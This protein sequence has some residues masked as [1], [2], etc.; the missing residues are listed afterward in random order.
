MDAPFRIVYGIFGQGVV[1]LC[2][3][4][5]HEG[6]KMEKRLCAMGFFCA[7]SIHMVRAVQK[8]V[9]FSANN[10]RNTANCKKS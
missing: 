5:P 2:L 7:P 1:A 4:P 9:Q 10:F 6:P 8:F 3:P